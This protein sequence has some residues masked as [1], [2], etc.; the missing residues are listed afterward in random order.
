MVLERTR[1]VIEHRSFQDIT[2]YLRP[3]DL[4]VMNN[5]RVLP[6]RLIGRW[7]PTGSA[8]SFSYLPGRHPME[9]GRL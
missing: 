4:L 1:G 7:A 9:N 8:K 5:T 3:G 6:A 2:G